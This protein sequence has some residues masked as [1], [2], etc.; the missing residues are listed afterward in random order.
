MKIFI[1]A[2]CFIAA[3][4]SASAQCDRSVILQ[5]VTGRSV[6]GDTRDRDM[7][8][9]A[10]AQVSKE[11]IVLI[12]TLGGKTS[13]ITNTINQVTTCDWKEYLVNGKTIYKVTTDK[14][15][16]HTEPSIIR[17]TSKNGKTTM[18]FGSDPDTDGG[19]ELDVTET[20]ST[21]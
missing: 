17:L 19:L 14:G 4:F 18:Y 5:S 3:G 1:L 12:I 16:G 20:K 13:T 2:I 6:Q 10:T 8:I 15:D 7:T 21:N 11:K 9:E